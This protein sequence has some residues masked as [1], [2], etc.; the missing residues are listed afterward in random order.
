MG[1]NL[2]DELEKTLKNAA[3]WLYAVAAMSLVNMILISTSTRFLAGL[4]FSELFLLFTTQGLY[5]AITVVIAI[6]FFFL[7][8]KV[9]RGS[10]GAMITALVLYISECLA[11]ILFMMLFI[12]VEGDDGKI[13]TFWDF[14]KDVVFHILI[15]ISLIAGLVAYLKIKKITAKNESVKNESA[16]NLQVELNQE[17]NF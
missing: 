16:K 10:G 12:G 9:R 3:Y 8:V 14:A 2:M 4:Y 6:L 1:S 15:L 5:I 13:I 7:G 17:D 11:F